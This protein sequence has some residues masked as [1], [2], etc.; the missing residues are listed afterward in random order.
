MV[1]SADQILMGMIRDWYSYSRNP[2]EEELKK[3]LNIHE[4]KIRRI[5]AYYGIIRE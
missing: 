3:F 4:D 5:D 2:D 1:S